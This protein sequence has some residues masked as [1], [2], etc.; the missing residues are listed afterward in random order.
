[1]DIKSQHRKSSKNNDNMFPL[2]SLVFFPFIFG[3]VYSDD[4][5]PI[6]FDVPKSVSDHITFAKE[7]DECVIT[8]VEVDSFCIRYL[9]STLESLGYD[10]DEN[11]T[12]EYMNNII[13]D[14]FGEGCF[15]SDWTVTKQLG[16]GLY[17][18]VYSTKGPDGE[19]GAMK[20]QSTFQSEW[21][22]S[23][24]IQ[25]MKLF[26]YVGI[27]TTF[28]NHCSFG[29]YIHMTHTEK[30]DMIVDKY[31]QHDVSDDNLDILAS[32]II[33]VVR[34]MEINGL[35][36]KDFHVQN[37]G[38]TLNDDK[39]T[40]TL[41]VIDPQKSDFHGADSVQEMLILFSYYLFK[42][43]FFFNQI[44]REKFRTVFGYTFPVLYKDILI[45]R[46]FNNL[47]ESYRESSKKVGVALCEKFKSINNSTFS[48]D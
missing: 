5:S 4:F 36:H 25:M 22:I 29:E 7:H 12:C 2:T 48:C 15:P 45:L 24:E 34:R 47:P 39:K 6:T 44:L 16:H 35:N 28:K 10:W 32:K 3:T 30:V 23:K 8:P 42:E 14:N 38:L 46:N 17:A 21:D 19:T 40:A 13:H 9:D 11:R 26:E 31:I 1:M 37:I 18:H 43:N 20:V 41:K 33:E 27:S